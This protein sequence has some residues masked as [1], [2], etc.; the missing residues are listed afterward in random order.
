MYSIKSKVHP[1]PM[2]RNNNPLAS[3]RIVNILVGKLSATALA[4]T[5]E[6]HNREVSQCSEDILIM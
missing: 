3:M 2:I 4:L 6:L 1:S 5:D